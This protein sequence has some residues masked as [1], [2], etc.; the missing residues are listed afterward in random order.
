VLSGLAVAAAGGLAGC[1]GV[2][3]EDDTPTPEPDHLRERQ[4]FVADALELSVPDPIDTVDTPDEVDVVVLPATTDRT[5]ET[6]V[7]WIEGGMRIVLVGSH[8]QSTWLAWQDSEAYAAAYPDHRGRA[9]SCSSSSSGS[10]GGGGSDESDCE[11]PELLVGWEPAE[12][13]P[14]TYRKTWGG[15]DDP[16]DEQIVAGIEDAYEEY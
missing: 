15:T 11:P 16:S 6:A 5:A 2:L 3:A 13:P 14:T 1:G 9:E 7:G 4:L 10:G 12:G 8:S